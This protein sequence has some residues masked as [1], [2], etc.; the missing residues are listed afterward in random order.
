MFKLCIRRVAAVIVHQNHEADG[1]PAQ[2]IERHDPP[3]LELG[4]R[5]LP[6]HKLCTR[7]NRHR[8]SPNVT[9]LL[10]ATALRYGTNDCSVTASNVMANVYQGEHFCSFFSMHGPGGSHPD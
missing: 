3:R 4:Y 9:V 10:A 2:Q 1:Q 8:A 7:L 5:P 6:I